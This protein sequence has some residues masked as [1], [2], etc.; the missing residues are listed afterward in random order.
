MKLPECDLSAMFSASG[1]LFFEDRETQ[2]AGGILDTF[3]EKNNEPG[4][5]AHFF[6][7]N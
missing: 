1:L 7:T 3:V 6:V 2:E 5:V 4:L